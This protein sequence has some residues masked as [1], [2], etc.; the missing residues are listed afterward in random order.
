MLV[1]GDEGDR[2][3]A[4]IQFPQG[5]STVATAQTAGVLAFAT[6]GRPSLKR[7]RHRRR[8]ASTVHSRGIPPPRGG[9]E[10]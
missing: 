6:N 2:W 9:W 1:F 10:G 7:R 4:A 3:L 8:D 5:F